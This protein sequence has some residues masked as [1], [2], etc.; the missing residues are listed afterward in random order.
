M[1]KLK[2]IVIAISLLIVW[3]N[4]SDAIHES[5]SSDALYYAMH[6]NKYENQPFKK[7]LMLWNAMAHHTSLVWLYGV[8]GVTTSD[9]MVLIDIGEDKLRISRGRG[10]EFLEVHYN[11][12]NYYF[13]QQGKFTYAYHRVNKT[14]ETYDVHPTSEEQ[15]AFFANVDRMIQ[16]ILDKVEV[17]ET[18]KQW[19][20]DMFAP[21]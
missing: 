3:W 4:V 8:E 17:P 10:A 9:N 11:G 2:I 13:N 20:F 14:S 21:Y 12:T 16:P 7:R 15:E 18:N 5:Y 1:K 19:V 6:T